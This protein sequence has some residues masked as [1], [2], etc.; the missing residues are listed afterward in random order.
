[1]R[2]NNYSSLDVDPLIVA[3]DSFRPRNEIGVMLNERVDAKGLAIVDMG[4]DLSPP[5][6]YELAKSV[7]ITVPETM[8]EISRRAYRR[9]VTRIDNRRWL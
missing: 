3:A 2:D 6:L 1:M 5:N 4:D 8:L 9:V 7:G